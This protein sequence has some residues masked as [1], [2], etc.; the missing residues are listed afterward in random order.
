MKNG[1][2]IRELRPSDS[3]ANFS[4]GPEDRGLENF[5]KQD[6]KEY[7]E[8]SLAY[9][10]VFVEGEEVLG[11]ISLV[12][13]EIYDGD[14]YVRDAI[15][16]EGVNFPRKSFP[17]VKIA[18]LAVNKEHQKKGI[19][20][21]LVDF[22]IECSRRIAEI[23]GCRFIVLDA[24]EEAIGFYVRQYKFELASL[25]R[26]PNNDTSPLFLDLNKR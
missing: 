2:R 11:A 13:S 24:N 21:Q 12:C 3:F 9:T 4:L 10:Y 16:L 6:S 26:D 25:S 15:E 5:F 14:S 8:R 7:Q 1:V 18:R 23:A 19:G 17:A 20:T 22:S